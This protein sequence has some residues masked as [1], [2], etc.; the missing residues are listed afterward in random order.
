MQP[1]APATRGKLAEF[2]RLPTIEG[3]KADFRMNLINPTLYSRAGYSIHF[4][5][6]GQN[7]KSL[8]GNLFAVNLEALPACLLI[9][10]SVQ[11]GADRSREDAV[12]P[13]LSQ[14]LAGLDVTCSRP[15]LG[16]TY[17][18]VNCNNICAFEIDEYISE[19]RQD[20]EFGFVIVEVNRETK[21]ST[22]ASIYAYKKS[23]AFHLC[24]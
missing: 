6:L 15:A 19:V 8:L 3:K 16:K 9:G 20:A 24:T 18:N 22:F 2:H 14:P 11:D 7:A 10:S 12:A 21:P 17:G 5:H 4:P 1:F 13:R 23:P